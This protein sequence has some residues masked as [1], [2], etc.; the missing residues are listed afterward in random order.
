MKP[1]GIRIIGLTGGI[2]SGKSTVARFFEMRGVP[3]IDA[4][5]L[6]RLAVE[7]GTPGLARVTA[8]FGGGMLTAEGA[9]DRKKVA[10]LI[11]SD[12]EA[13]RSLESIIHPEIKRL[14]EEALFSLAARGHRLAVYM[15]PLLIEAG[16][17]DRVDEVWVVTVRPEVQLQRLM[18]RDGI[19]REEAERIIASQMPLAEKAAHG[20]IVID[21]SGTPEETTALLERVWNEELEGSL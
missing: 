7:P 15:A 5:R 9:L 2:A 17:T 4:D 13:R 16:A 18:C 3:V 8:R 1:D 20:R 14:A 12:P 11:F 19:T 6:A 21:N 10:D